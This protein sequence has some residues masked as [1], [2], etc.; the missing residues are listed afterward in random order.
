MRIVVKFDNLDEWKEFCKEYDFEV[1]EQT[2]GAWVCFDE[3]RTILNPS[4]WFDENT[5]TG[6]VDFD[7]RML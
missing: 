3:Q 1:E 7:H 6:E 2:E 4:G 5:Q